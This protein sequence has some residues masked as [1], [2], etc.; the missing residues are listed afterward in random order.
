MK[1]PRPRVGPSTPTR[2]RRASVPGLVTVLALLAMSLAAACGPSEAPPDPAPGAPPPPPA[3]TSPP[4]AASPVTAPPTQAPSPSPPPDPAAAP[5]PSAPPAADVDAATRTLT[6]IHVSNRRAQLE[7]S[8]CRLGHLGGVERFARWLNIHAPP[9]ARRL[10]IEGGDA[11]LPTPPE[12]ITDA[13]RALATE[14][15]DAL[16]RLGPDLLALGD[17]DLDLGPETLASV[18]QGAAFPILVANVFDWDRG[19]PAFDQGVVISVS[20]VKVGVTAIVEPRHGSTDERRGD[21][22]WRVLDPAPVLA[23]QRDALRAAGAE[24][25]VVAAH[26][27]RARAEELARSIDGL[28]VMLLGDDSDEPE[29]AAW[30]GHTLLVDA[31]P[32]AEHA[33]AVTLTLTAGAPA[34]LVDADRDARLDA[35][36]SLL[37]ARLERVDVGRPYEDPEAAVR[38]RAALG[39]LA[40]ERAAAA[41]DPLGRHTASVSLV[42]INESLDPR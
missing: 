31:G 23:T 32:G 18:A 25:I 20:G 39:Q 38:V 17:R 42:P 6:L 16:N 36:R 22:P 15:A 11:L 1:H 21:E 9:S 30:V 13:A 40:E 19:E 10:V 5:A 33:V 3:E 41:A 28:D 2:R 27:H 12:P 7:P 29:P 37:E 14:T 24:L 26:V 34:G 4:P 8:V 35:A